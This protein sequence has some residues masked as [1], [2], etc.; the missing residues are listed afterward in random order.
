MCLFPRRSFDLSTYVHGSHVS[1]F[2]RI[3]VY[4]GLLLLHNSS[5]LPV[6][7]HVPE[8]ENNWIINKDGYFERIIR[9]CAF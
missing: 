3:C 9:M 4:S 7:I 6:F 8:K 1:T 2:F 5:T